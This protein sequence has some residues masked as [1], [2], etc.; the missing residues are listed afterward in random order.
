MQ[1]IIEFAF[2]VLMA[3]IT[4]TT[5]YWPFMTTCNGYCCNTNKTTENSELKSKETIPYQVFESSDPLSRYSRN[6]GGRPGIAVLNT[7]YRG[8]ASIT[9]E[10]QPLYT[11]A[12]LAAQVRPESNDK[13]PTFINKNKF[14]VIT[15]SGMHGT[16]QEIYDTVVMAQALAKSQGVVIVN[17]VKPNSPAWHAWQRLIRDGVLHWKEEDLLAHGNQVWVKG[18]YKSL[19]TNT[20][21]SEYLYDIMQRYVAIDETDETVYY[22]ISQTRENEIRESYQRD[23]T[24][25]VTNLTTAFHAAILKVL[26]PKIKIEIEL[27]EE[28]A[29]TH[30]LDK[31]VEFLQ[32]YILVV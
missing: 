14:P 18:R 3:I 22:V 11:I 21:V 29:K 8:L 24:F 13:H 28:A 25:T 20:A 17:E 12:K 31:A 4:V 10:H 23:S 26:V 9:I 7:F 16:E 1:V 15:V 6:V 27:A 30:S 5:L 19:N 32:T 2:I